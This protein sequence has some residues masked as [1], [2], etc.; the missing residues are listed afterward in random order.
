M[1]CSRTRSAF[2]AG[3]PTLPNHRPVSAFSFKKIR[4]YTPLF[5][6]SNLRIFSRDLVLSVAFSRLLSPSS[7]L[8]PLCFSWCSQRRVS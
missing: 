4:T 2:S 8:Q 6:V 7:Q 1:R 3:P 5:V